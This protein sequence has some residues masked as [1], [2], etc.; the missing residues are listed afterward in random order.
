MTFKA[1]ID[2]LVLVLLKTA[3]LIAFIPD[4]NLTSLIIIAVP[5][6]KT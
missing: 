5:A 4:A 3:K 1:S 2:N 6:A